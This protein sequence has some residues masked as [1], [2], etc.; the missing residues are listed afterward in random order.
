MK[1]I[2]GMHRVR[3][4]EIRKKGQMDGKKEIESG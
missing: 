3:G 1:V 4:K 2:V